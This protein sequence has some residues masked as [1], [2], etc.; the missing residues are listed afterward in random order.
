MKN[1]AVLIITIFTLSFINIYAQN[2]VWSVPPYYKDIAQIVPLPTVLPPGLGYTGNPATNASNA[3]QD[4][5]GDLLFFIVDDEIFDKEGY[6]IGNLSW[7]SSPSNQVKG[8]SEIA[9]IPQP[10]NCSVYYI[11]TAGSEDYN[12]TNGNKKPYLAK[13]DFSQASDLNTSRLGRLTQCV[14]IQSILPSTATPVVGQPVRQANVYM[15]ASKLRN[16]NSRLVF[17]STPYRLYRFKVDVNGFHYENDIDILTGVAGGIPSYTIWRAEMELIE[18]GSNYRLAFVRRGLVNG[19]SVG[20]GIYIAN[21]N[22]N[23]DVQSHEDLLIVE[24][25][26]NSNQFPSVHGLEFSPDGDILYITHET[27]NDNPFAFEYYD[28]NNSS[29]GIQPVPN[30]SAFQS[31][32]YEFSQIEIGRNGK[33]YLAHSGGLA[34]LDDPNNPS[35]SSFNPNYLQFSYL[36]NNEGSSNIYSTQTSFML[37]D[38]IDGMDYSSIGYP[39]T[40]NITTYTAQVSETWEPGQNPWSNTYA[41]I[42]MQG[43]LVIPTGKN[44]VIKNMTFRFA[45]EAK[46]VVEPGGKLTLDK[47]VFTNAKVSCD[48]NEGDYWQG[49]QVYGTTNQHQF[50][51]NNPTYQGMLELKNGS[52]I[53]YASKAATNRKDGSWSQIGGVI[54]ST[55]SKFRNNRRDVEFMIYQNFHPTNSNINRDNT[56]SFTDTEFLSNDNFIEGSPQQPHVSLWKVQGINFKNCHFAN[57]L[58]TNKTLSDA[59]REGITALDASFKVLPR[60]DSPPLPQGSSCPSNL[61]L[62]SSFTGLEFAVQIA[63]AGISDAVTITQTDFT[64]NVWGVY[65]DEFDN[66]NINRNDFIIG[67]GGYSSS[68]TFGNGI[69]LDNSTGFIVEENSVLNTLTAGKTSG[70][71]VNNSGSADNQ[72]YKNTL[73]NLFAGTQ[74]D[75]INRKLDLHLNTGLQFLCNDYVQNITAITVNYASPGNGIR[76]YQGEF[77]PKTS[78]GNTFLLNNMDIVNNTA[79]H[80]NYYH[81]GGNTQP[82]DPNGVSGPV[83]VILAD[84][85]NACPTSF[86][87][88]V[89]MQDQLI[90]ELADYETDLASFNTSYTNLQYNY[91]SLIDN[92]DTDILQ[93]QIVTNWSDNAWNLRNNLMQESPYL[94]TEALLTAAGENILPNAM[95]LEVLL[96]NPDATRGE[97]FITE[98]NEVSNNALPEY[99]LNY[100]RNNWDTETVR[101]TL[102]GELASFQSKIANASNFIKYLEKSKD[103]HTYAERHN[104]VLMGEGISNKIGLMDFFVENSEWIRADSVL[105]ALNS[106]ESIQGDLVLLEDYDNYITFRSSLGARNVA[107]LDSSEI[108]YLE[109]LAEQGNRASGYAENILCFFY[110]ICYEKEMPEGE[111]MAKMLTIPAPSLDEPTLE[112]IMYNIKVYPNPASD[113]TS[114]KWEI[115]DELNNAHYKIFDLN[116]REMAS[117]A[118]EGNEGEQVIDTRSLTNGAYIINIYNDGIMKFNSKLIV[119][120]EK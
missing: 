51:V 77:N 38:Q 59:P 91:I 19:S 35:T 10:G 89:V 66:V 102:E 5:N 64:N 52:I 11:V 93:G 98:L 88:G 92:G 17:I 78:A 113:F 45:P 119:S 83:E 50:P 111:S 43:N 115:F 107:Q 54:K 18:K 8:T 90:T 55:N 72:V 61:L 15:A 103:E 76:Y 29:A 24:D 63:G 30:I 97:N 39:S 68:L 62:R 79:S 82:N 31:K 53:E 16:D 94:S 46:V 114:I 40:H 33:L 116:G 7:I 37:P 65:V 57:N 104:T 13:L 117:G 32:N 95:L 99:M 96:A 56:S 87:N 118:I 44:I 105:Q 60:C 100:V 23:G 4:A 120:K 34:A 109:T 48:D 108:S 28:F 67:N 47:S 110:G 58:T 27:D 20:V 71:V 49:I 73:N 9:I 69:K 2:S 74:A 106:D 36:A 42:S 85:S 81:F 75:R 26:Q 112:E 12:S 80:F 101:T 22:Q 84:F 21:L 3:M 1:L 14:S 70:I 6:M 41:Q 25:Q 86:T